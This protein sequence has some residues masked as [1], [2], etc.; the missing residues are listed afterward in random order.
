MKQL[1]SI[2]LVLFISPVW[3]LPLRSFVALPVAQGDAIFRFIAMH[4][5]KSKQQNTDV[6][7]VE[8]AYGISS[9]HMVMLGMPYR[10]SPSGA[11]QTGDVSALYRY[12]IFQKDQKKSSVIGQLMKTV[13]VQ[14]SLA[15]PVVTFMVVTK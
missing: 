7:A 13:M 11:N 14:L 2:F 12:T 5:E 4:N 9:K 8:A 15:L 6:L 3:A 1:L 10:L